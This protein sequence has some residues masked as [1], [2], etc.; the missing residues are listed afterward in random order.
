MLK[1]SKPL[2]AVVLAAGE[3]TRMKSSLP[4]PLHRICGRPMILHVLA[5]LSELPLD[6]VVVVVGHGSEEV[7]KVVTAEA[8]TEMP[9]E[10]VE[11]ITQ[12]G[13][14]DA[15][16]V[17]L[18]AMPE[19]LETDNDG[20]VIVL[21]GDTPLITSETIEKLVSEHLH[22]DQVATLLTAK[23]VDPFGYGRILRDKHLD[24]L[25]IV[26]QADADAAT[27]GT[28]E[29]CTS[30]YVFKYSVLGPGLRRL[31]PQNQQKEYYLT[32]IVEVL[33]SAGYRLDSVVL[34]DPNEA[35]GVNDKSQLAAATK[36]LT[37]R[38]NTKWMK[39][40]VTIQAPEHCHIDSTV[41]LG[42]EV[43][44][45][46]NTILRGGTHI[47]DYAMV[48]PNCELTDCVV[49]EGAVI[50]NTVAESSQISDFAVVGPFAHLLP[51]TIIDTKVVTG[52]FFVGNDPQE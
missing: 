42:K 34:D 6:K 41:V 45:L 35:M 46:A 51:G 49:G 21:P 16:A 19:T 12:R 37:D 31:V 8:P 40:G 25:R 32:D 47:G 17:G 5:A 36:V 22:G 38:I 26:E 4:K 14:G 33:A 1:T 50:K 48:G 29:I 20:D 23:V 30:L 11:Q 28:N 52:P 10:F 24:V 2:V 44:L 27:A 13:T 9:I 43:T 15:V 7:T 39:S 18:T 3:G